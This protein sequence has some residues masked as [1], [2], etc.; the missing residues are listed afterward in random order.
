MI[1]EL[2]V[3]FPDVLRHAHDKFEM[4]EI[5]AVTLFQTKKFSLCV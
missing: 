1:G 4:C 5:V 3:V 2:R